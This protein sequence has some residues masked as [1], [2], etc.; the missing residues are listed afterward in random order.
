[1]V[2]LDRER[3]GG[4]GR[5]PSASRPTDRMIAQPMLRSL[6]RSQGA[7][8]ILL[9]LPAL[10][11]L[12]GLT[13]YPVL[14]GMWLSLHHKHSFFPQQSWAGLENYWFLFGD[15]EF[16]E[17]IWRGVVYSVSTIVLQIVLGVAAALALNQRFPGRNLARG[18]VLFPYMIPTVVAVILW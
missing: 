8:G 7:V 10:S 1:V 9:L 3:A 5:H 6:S 2:D 12:A 17:S 18:I 13:L 16:G 4:A 15:P 14:Y 11:L